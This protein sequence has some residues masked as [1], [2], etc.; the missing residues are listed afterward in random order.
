[1]QLSFWILFAVLV[2]LASADRL[3]I[4]SCFCNEKW[5]ARGNLEDYTE[6]GTFFRF[7][8]FN[9]HLGRTYT[10]NL[11]QR[12]TGTI[13]G[14]LGGKET[15][16]RLP[17][18]CRTYEDGNTLCYYRKPK[19]HRARVIFNG[20]KR[21]LPY[22]GHARPNPEFQRQA[23]DKCSNEYC[24]HDVGLTHMVKDMTNVANYNVDPICW[25]DPE[26]KCPHAFKYDWNGTALNYGF[27]ERCIAGTLTFQ[28]GFP[29]RAIGSKRGLSWR[30]IFGK[31]GWFPSEGTW[32]WFE[33][34][35]WVGRWF[36]GWFS[37]RRLSG[38]GLSRAFGSSVDFF[39]FLGWFQQIAGPRTLRKCKVCTKHYVF[40]NAKDM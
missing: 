29:R 10:L 38:T 18:I 1:M 33:S 20:H 26:G 8:Y 2:C 16:P 12:M 36:C 35:V 39:D 40:A 5:D 11:T 31:L 24:I 4:T 15:M 6:S 21:K 17:L 25:L 28:G 30:T 19:Q 34:R 9:D 23:W 7:D 27:Q 13:F 32:G 14:K 3:N 22:H 37:K